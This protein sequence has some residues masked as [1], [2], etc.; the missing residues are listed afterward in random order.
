M[1]KRRYKKLKK[2]TNKY[3]TKGNIGLKCN[4]NKVLSLNEYNKLIILLKKIKGI[5]IIKRLQTNL[6]KRKRSSL[7]GMGHGKSPLLGEYI[8]I[9]ENEIILELKK[10]TGAL[11]QRAEVSK[12]LDIDLISLQ[13][14]LR[15]YKWI[16]TV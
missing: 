10:S 14:L 16:T 7:L 3:I 13:I 6:L 12:W 4:R 11:T 15:N 9:R 1:H 5:Q 8:K 2:T